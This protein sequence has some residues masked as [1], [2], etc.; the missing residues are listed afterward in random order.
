M[1]RRQMRCGDREVW[2]RNER[3]ERSVPG[4][5]MDALCSR[6]YGFGCFFG[7]QGS[8]IL[9]EYSFFGATR[10]CLQWNQTPYIL[11]RNGSIP[12]YSPTKRYLNVRYVT[13]SSICLQFTVNNI[14]IRS[15]Y[16]ILYTIYQSN[17]NNNHQI[18]GCVYCRMS[19]FLK[20]GAPRRGHGRTISL[21]ENQDSL[22]C[23]A[24]WPSRTNRVVTISEIELVER[25]DVTRMMSEARASRRG[26]G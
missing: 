24:R 7:A 21:A 25:P 6:A 14:P 22:V 18:E 2:G 23:Q 10:L 9:E 17:K 26:R 1:S 20:G 11:E 13:I 8:L 3:R 16:S 4:R 19:I 15:K 12:Q 5:G